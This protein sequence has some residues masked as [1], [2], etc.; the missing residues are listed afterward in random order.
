MDYSPWWRA[1]RGGIHGRDEFSVEG[2]VVCGGLIKRVSPAVIHTY[3][4]YMSTEYPK[5]GGHK[6][7]PPRRDREAQRPTAPSHWPGSGTAVIRSNKPHGGSSR[8]G[9]PIA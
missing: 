7:L 9:R 6:I 4:E 3:F 2:G 8:R 1:V 5:T